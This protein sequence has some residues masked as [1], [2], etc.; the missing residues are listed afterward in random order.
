M[1][2]AMLKTSIIKKDL[3]PFELEQLN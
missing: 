2:S 1:S 3:S